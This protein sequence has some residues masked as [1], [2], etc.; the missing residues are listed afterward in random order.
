M[1]ILWNKIDRKRRP[2]SGWKR[3]QNHNDL[4]SRLFVN[5]WRANKTTTEKRQNWAGQFESE[6]TNHRLHWESINQSK[7]AIF[8]PD[9][10][11]QIWII[12]LCNNR[13]MII[14]KTDCLRSENVVFWPNSIFFLSEASSAENFLTLNKNDNFLNLIQFRNCDQILYGWSI[15][16]TR[17]EGRVRSWVPF[18]MPNWQLS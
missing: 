12:I 15:R 3:M 18:D 16:P 1:H 17:R 8:P 13:L 7:A 14:I 11:L 9:F 10:E 5:L 2:K 6:L 4:P